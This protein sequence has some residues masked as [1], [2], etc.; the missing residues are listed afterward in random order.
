MDRHDDRLVND[1]R[2]RVDETPFY[3]WA[4]I[5]IASA[6]EGEVEVAM[7]VGAGHLNIQGL[8]HGGLLA[9]LADTAMG[10]AVRTRLEPGS[11]HVTIQLGVQFLSP[12]RPGRIVARGRV[13]RT[14]RQIANAEADVV[15]AGGKLLARAQST[16][17]VMA[18]R[19]NA[20]DGDPDQ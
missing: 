13:V 15:D 11:R 2:R 20:R 5:S 14:G 3:G 10:L 17:A 7:E 6:R 1:L 9:T 12:G 16:V 18:E 8:V 4:G 19:G